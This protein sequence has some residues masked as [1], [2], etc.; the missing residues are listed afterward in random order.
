MLLLS[1]HKH[2]MNFNFDFSV[3]R[4]VDAVHTIIVHD[5]PSAHRPISPSANLCS[6][7]AVVKSVVPTVLH[8]TTENE[9]EDVQYIHT[10][11]L[12]Y[13]MFTRWAAPEVVLD[14]FYTTAAAS[15]L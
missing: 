11:R 9:Q 7:R 14:P 12:R 13:Y 8:L 1:T 2:M 10:V 15:W 4:A 5:R 3:V 6:S